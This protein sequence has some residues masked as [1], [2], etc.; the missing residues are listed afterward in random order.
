MPYLTQNYSV[1]SKGVIAMGCA[2]SVSG[3]LH[4]VTE[5]AEGRA[6]S[7]T[8]EMLRRDSRGSVVHAF[9]HL[10]PHNGRARAAGRMVSQMI[11]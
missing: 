2:A 6:I 7:K 10:P 8:K 9:G 5:T 11:A 1:S 3:A 4:Y